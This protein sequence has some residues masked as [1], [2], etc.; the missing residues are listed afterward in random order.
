MLIS[1]VAVIAPVTA[2]VEPSNVMFASAFIASAPVAVITLLLTPFV[3]K[4]DTSTE[5]ASAATSIPVPAPTAKEPDVVTVP[6]KP[7]P[8]VT[9]VTV[10]CL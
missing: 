7:F 9:E 1:P 5:I 8:P 10:P 2:K 3:M 4:S 6:V